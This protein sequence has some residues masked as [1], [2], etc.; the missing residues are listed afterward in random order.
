MAKAK[1]GNKKFYKKYLKALQFSKGYPKQ[2][3]DLIRAAPVPV[4]KLLGNSAILAS[5]GNIKLS[6]SQKKQFR[7][8]KKLFDILTSRSVGFEKKRNFLVQRGG[9]AFIP[10]LLSTVVPLVG[11]LIF[12]A[13]QA[14]TSDS[15]SS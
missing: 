13:I 9:F 14:H 15:S 5:R 6:P 3:K 4:L 10:L 7:A 11:D 1:V 2:T 8:H 12:R